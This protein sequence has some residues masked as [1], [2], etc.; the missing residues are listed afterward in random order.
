MALVFMDSFD[1]YAAADTQLKYSGG[2]NWGSMVTG[3]LGTGQAGRMSGSTGPIRN[4]STTYST[5]VMGFRHRIAGLAAVTAIMTFRDGSNNVVATLAVLSSGALAWYRGNNSTQVV[6]SAGAL[7][8]VNAI[9]YI[10]VKVTLATGTTGSVDIHLNGTS[11]AS[12]SSVQTANTTASIQ[13]F[14]YTGAGATNSDFDDFYMFDTTGAENNDF[15]GDS[16]ITTIMPNGNGRVNQWARTGG[17]VSG[18]YTAVDETTPDGDT[19]YVSS[20]TAGQIDCYTL[21]S[22]GSPTAVKCV[23]ICTDVRKDDAATRTVAHGVGNGTTENF[24]AGTNVGSTYGY[25]VRGLDTNPL[26]SAA[27]T[28]GDLT[29]LQSAIKCIS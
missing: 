12:A 26:T 17:T 25:L 2:A 28:T 27:W 14:Q 6:S 3:L 20:A 23:Q 11:V 21:G 7:I 19:S 15:A 9:N 5:F 18:N 1:H 8:A 24:D 13:S 4:L 16:K 22:A 10:E 29:T